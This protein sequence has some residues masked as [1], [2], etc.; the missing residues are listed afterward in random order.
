[1][2]AR[3]LFPILSATDPGALAAFYTAGLGANET[4][5]FPADGTPV[6]IYLSL[7][8]LGLGIALR[9]P[10]DGEPG[11]GVALWVYTNDVDDMTARLS[12]LGARV[13]AE[14]ADQP[15]GERMAS[16]KDPEGHLLHVGAKSQGG[17]DEH[18]SGTR[19]PTGR[20]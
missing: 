14:P 8:P 16:I 11:N 9:Q 4:Y 17:A 18:G 15:W 2:S 13:V 19:A 1:M 7:E 20:Q 6:Y 5:R 3:E 10:G 12:G